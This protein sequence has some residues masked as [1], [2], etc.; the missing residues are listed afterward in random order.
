MYNLHGVK[1]IKISNIH[2]VSRSNLK[3]GLL[4]LS[5]IPGLFNSFMQHRRQQEWACSRRS[6]VIVKEAAFPNKLPAV[7]SASVWWF[8][9]H[10][11]EIAGNSPHRIFEMCFF[12]SSHSQYN[13]VGEPGFGLQTESS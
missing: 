1:N 4:A 2:A 9:A 8:E 12:F 3:E 11:G 10:S 13:T 7:Q 6:S 5:N